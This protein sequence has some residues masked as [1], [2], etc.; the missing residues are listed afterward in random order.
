LITFYFN[1]FGVLK[2]WRAKE[3]GGWVGINYVFFHCLLA[4]I[5]LYCSVFLRAG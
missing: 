4:A 3:A 1:I 2:T 5:F